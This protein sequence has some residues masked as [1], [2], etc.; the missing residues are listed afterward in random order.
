MLYEIKHYSYFYVAFKS[1]GKIRSFFFCGYYSPLRALFTA[2]SI[3]RHLSNS[4]LPLYPSYICQGQWDN[5][6]LSGTVSRSF[7]RGFS[8]HGQLAHPIAGIISPKMTCT[9]ASCA[10]WMIKYLTFDVI[11]GGPTIPS[12]RYGS[13]KILFGS[14][15]VQDKYLSDWML[16]NLKIFSINFSPTLLFSD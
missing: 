11:G 9:L 7:S 12:I 10:W 15:T 2:F 3:S 13:E 1:F 8:R 14:Y 5:S 16:F 4:L 6:N